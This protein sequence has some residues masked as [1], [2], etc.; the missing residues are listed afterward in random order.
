[1][2]YTREE[3]GPMKLLDISIGE[4][5]EALK[6]PFWHPRRWFGREHVGVTVMVR[7]FTENGFVC[8]PFSNPVPMWPDDRMK[9]T[10]DPQSGGRSMFKRMQ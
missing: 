3:L 1:M 4:L 10:C 7:I 2:S 6:L 5:P 8:E 9:I